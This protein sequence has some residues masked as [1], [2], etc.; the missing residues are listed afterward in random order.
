MW[1]WTQDL[2]IELSV[3]GEPPPPPPGAFFGRDELIE[4]IVGLAESLA[5]IALIGAGGIGK[6]SIALSVLHDSRIKKRFDENRRFIRCEQFQPTRADFLNHLSITIG[7]GVENPK[8]LTPLRRFLSSKEMF[9]V[10][11]NAESVLDPQGTDARDIYAV[12]EELSRFGN[13]CLCITSRISTVPPRCRRPTI[14][15]LSMESACDIFYDIYRDNGRS[16]IVKQLIQELDFHTLSITLLATTAA[17]NTWDHNRLAREWSTHRARAL[18]T[19]YNESLEATIE[20]SLSSPTFRDLGPVARE[21]LGVIAFFP[22]G[23][24][25]NNLD[26]LFPTIPSRTAIFDKFCALSLTHRSNNFIT[27]LAP[28]R[29]YLSP[30]DPR[31]SPLLCT[32]KDRYFSRLRLLGDLEPD[33]P[34]FGESRW[35]TSEDTNV[36]HLLNV[37]TSFDTDS[38]DTWAACADFMTHLRWHKPRSTVL[39]SR[40]EG[41]SGDH[42]SKLCCLFQLS[43]LF[44]SLGNWVDQKQLLT[45]VLVLERGRGTDDRVARTLRELAEANRLLGLHGE[46]IQQSREALEICE[47]LGDA[48]GQAK[49]WDFIG[50]SLFG[51]GQ[52][53]AA[54][55]AESHAINLFRDQDRGYWVCISHRLLGLIY[56]SKGERGKAVQHLE[57]AIEIASPFDWHDQLF[58]NYFNLAILSH[59]EDEFD[60]AQ[61]HIEQAKSHAIDDSYNLGRTMDW[62][63]AIW[64]SQGRLEE[65]KAESLRA[66]ETFE[67]LG[68]TADLQWPRSR[69]QEIERAIESNPSGEFS[70]HDAASYCC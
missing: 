37:F 9:L 51:D 17:H 8:D 32:T 63:A 70:G 52:L 18:R 41:L 69:L 24:N 5:P 4:K 31:T 35:I 23:V 56:Q 64:Y 65:A 45:R 61:S 29:D 66:L 60:A 27:M 49:C 33:Q 2:T 57:A 62:Q 53:D 67:K 34:G 6:T 26:W 11:D 47:R 16:D 38:G 42:H 54:E 12:V 21:V 39:G 13:I 22:Q 55:E 25:E 30:Q 14:P 1:S 58:W 7:A 43:L 19:Y 50:W 46:G 59:D 48:V 3:L 10:L 44:K 28:L 36:E 68:A 40:V 15:T 20:L